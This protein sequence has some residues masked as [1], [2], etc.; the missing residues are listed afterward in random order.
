MLDP[1]PSDY[2]YPPLPSDSSASFAYSAL[3]TTSQDDP[4]SSADVASVDDDTGAN[5]SGP[6][7]S[8]I[9]QRWRVVIAIGGL[10]HSIAMHVS[11]ATPATC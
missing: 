5:G 1:Q 4:G 2:V 3:Q 6:P 8:G 10:S 7:G 9:P 11:A